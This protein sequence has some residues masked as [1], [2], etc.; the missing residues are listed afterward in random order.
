MMQAALSA[1]SGRKDAPVWLLEEGLS[2]RYSE[3]VKS[4]EYA[5][6]GMELPYSII[7]EWSKHRQ[8]PFRIAAAKACY[9]R[10]DI[11][12]KILESLVY[13]PHPDVRKAAAPLARPWR[14]LFLFE[15]CYNM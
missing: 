10:G 8:L 14:A 4:A 3:V 11:P 13:N 15:K 9:G 12:T 7:E 5:V 6:I 1:L 2:S